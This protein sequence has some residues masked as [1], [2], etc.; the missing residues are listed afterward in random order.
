MAGLIVVTGTGLAFSV[1]VLFFRDR[2][3]QY[4]GVSVAS[5][6]AAI[7]L[8]QLVYN[9]GTSILSGQRRVHVTGL[10]NSGRII[11]T[12]VL[13]ILF[14]YGGLKLT[15]LL[16]G[17]WLSLLAVTIVGLYLTNVKVTFPHWRHFRSLWEYAKFSWLGALKSRSF[18]NVDILIL[19]AFVSS[20]LVGIYSVAWSISKF[21]SL[22]DDAI[23]QTAFPEIS[24]SD[25]NE[26]PDA[27]ANLVTESFRF[28]GLTT[29]PGLVGA[30]L[31]GDRLLRIYGPEFQQGTAVLGLLIFAI[32]VYGYQKQ[33]LS[34]LNAIDRPDLAFRI[35]VVFIGANIAMNV[36]LIQTI[37]WV[38]AALATVFSAVIGLTLSVY[39]FQKFVN[40][41]I[42]LWNIGEQALAAFVMG[43]VVYGL[44]RLEEGYGL[45][46]HN[47][48]TVLAVVTIGAG[49]YFITLWMISSRFR[50]TIE[51]NIQFSQLLS[52]F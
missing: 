16:I 29:I 19:G 48:A 43:G 34:G 11:F 4:V 42:P 3:E 39:I 28:S 8:L 30:Y 32:I 18:N 31:V 40:F 38:G 21:L 5:F 44:L 2:V 15:G 17:Q 52:N 46:Q 50:E 33:V 24:Y 20:S 25:T 1:G 35:N 47:V 10:L 41:T 7:L 51:R 36:V 23:R 14:V 37:G 22:F 49:G 45:L 26:D 12:K 6:V 13:Q 9:I 27:V